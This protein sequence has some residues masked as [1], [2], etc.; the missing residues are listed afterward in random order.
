MTMNSR[1]LMDDILFALGPANEANALVLSISLRIIAEHVYDL[2]DATDFKHLL[3]ELADQANTASKPRSG[4]VIQRELRRS[5]VPA[6][7]RRWDDTCNRCG[8]VHQ[9]LAECG[10]PMGS[11]GICRCEH[12]ATP[13]RGSLRA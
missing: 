3:L 9:G 4:L 6:S 7:Q 8:H 5:A 1:D 13:A 11:A 10:E 2:S 12:E